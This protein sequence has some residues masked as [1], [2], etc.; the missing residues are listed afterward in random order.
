M[1]RNFGVM[2]LVASAAAMLTIGGSASATIRSLGALSAGNT[3]PT[4]AILSSGSFKDEWD[5]SVLS[6]ADSIVATVFNFNTPTNQNISGLHVGLFEGATLRAASGTGTGAL[7]ENE[8]I[9]PTAI[10]SGAP[11][12]P[13]W[14]MMLIGFGLVALQLRRKTR[15]IAVT[16]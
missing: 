11:E 16:A 10:V 5:F 8:S 6:P 1:M 9:P 2:V 7:G 13:I 15:S 14:S 3:Q 4:G 12:L